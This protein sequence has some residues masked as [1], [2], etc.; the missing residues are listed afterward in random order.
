[1]A[2]ER[3]LR[4]ADLPLAYSQ[5]FNPHPRIVIAM[6]LPVGCTGA[7]E[8]V[9]VYLEEVLDPAS[10]IAA[11]APALPVGIGVSSAIRALTGDPALPNQ[12]SGAEYRLS[13]AEVS[14]ENVSQRVDEL[15]AMERCQVEFR[16]KTYDLRPL[17]GPLS[18]H[19]DGGWTVIEALLLRSASGRIGRPDVLLEALDLAAHVRGVHREQ[20]VF[21]EAG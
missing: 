7:N 5:G 17:I 8:M 14:L 3:I 21:G 12:I 2:W 20:I 9:D 4:R 16:R 1:R 13:L 11:L 10:V 15:L 6:P 18:V 19:T